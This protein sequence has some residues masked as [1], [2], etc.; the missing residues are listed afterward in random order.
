M[1]MKGLVLLILFQAAL[2]SI[3]L[4][5]ESSFQVPFHEAT[6]QTEVR[7]TIIASGWVPWRLRDGAGAFLRGLG[8]FFL[9]V[10]ELSP[11]MLTSAY[12][13]T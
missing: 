3:R 10:T 2:G 11:T 9:F 4:K 13:E 8:L 1:C 5:N 12:I 7:T 6:V